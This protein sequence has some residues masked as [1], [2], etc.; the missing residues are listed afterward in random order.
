MIRY[1][2]FTFVIFNSLNLILAADSS[3]YETRMIKGAKWV[4]IQDIDSNLKADQIR[5]IDK[6]WDQEQHG[7]DKGRWELYKD[8]DDHLHVAFEI[9]N[10]PTV[11]K[12]EIEWW[13]E[14]KYSLR[15]LYNYHSNAKPYFENNQLIKLPLV[16]ISF[17]DK[18]SKIPNIQDK[19]YPGA[20]PYEQIAEREFPDGS[21]IVV[22]IEPSGNLRLAHSAATHDNGDFSQA[23]RELARLK[24]E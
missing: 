11:R 6:L 24:K 23:Y 2:F 13:F 10:W 20:K 19:P 14:D 18:A 4:S 15:S 22:V 9:S 8:K 17:D 1:L 7:E 12:N 21:K 16:G 3:L 5:Q